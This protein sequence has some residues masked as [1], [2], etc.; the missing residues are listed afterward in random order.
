MTCKLRVSHIIKIPPEEPITSKHAQSILI[1]LHKDLTRIIF[2]ILK[3]S[4]RKDYNVR[5]SRRNNIFY[6]GSFN[7]R[8]E[9][10]YSPGNN[11]HETTFFPDCSFSFIVG[12]E[13]VAFIEFSKIF[14][15]LSK[16]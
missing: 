7:G 4:F 16:R 14:F 3:L 5:T 12:L 2:N 13:D 11:F 15:F 1:E 6:N 10:P 9:T 8:A